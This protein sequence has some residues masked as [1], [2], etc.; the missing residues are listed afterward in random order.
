M[1]TPITHKHF[2]K[3]GCSLLWMEI[4]KKNDPHLY[5]DLICSICGKI[6]KGNKEGLHFEE[7]EAIMKIAG[8]TKENRKILK[9]NI[10]CADG[11]TYDYEFK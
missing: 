2:H 4:Y 8:D 9:K 1:K 7:Y 3:N 6:F 11:L 10:V 5:P